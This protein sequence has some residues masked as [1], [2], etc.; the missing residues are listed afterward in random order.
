MIQIRPIK[1]K[2]KAWVARLRQSL[3][4]HVGLRVVT[5]KAGCVLIMD[6]GETLALDASLYEG[7]AGFRYA[8]RQ[9]LAFSETVIH[10]V[11]VTQN[12]PA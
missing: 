11:G 5:I 4:S 1:M 6:R 9:F 10:A 7:L 12:A 2:L 8:L 3:A